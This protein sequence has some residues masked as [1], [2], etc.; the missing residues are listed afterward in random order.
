[1]MTGQVR[2]LCRYFECKSGSV[3]GSGVAVAGLGFG[4]CGSGDG[5]D[6]RGRAA[7]R[8]DRPL[9]GSS[10]SLHKPSPA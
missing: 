5:D 8:Q 3:V 9:I 2:G 1:M 6:K 7:D 10:R 4:S